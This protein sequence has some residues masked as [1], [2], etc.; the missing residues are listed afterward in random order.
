VAVFVGEITRRSAA[1]SVH[2]EQW[3]LRGGARRQREAGD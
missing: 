2:V 1:G 3:T